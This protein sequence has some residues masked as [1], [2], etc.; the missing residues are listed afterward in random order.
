[1]TT[2]RRPEGLEAGREQII[3]RAYRLYVR[4]QTTLPAYR[5]L[6][7]RLGLSTTELN[8]LIH[9]LY[10]AKKFKRTT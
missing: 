3:R 5:E 7:A 9:P 4:Y 1:M 8:L 6:A 2:P 10:V